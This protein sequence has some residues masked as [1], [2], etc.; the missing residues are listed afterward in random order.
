MVC[1]VGRY[2]CCCRKVCH[3][4]AVG[5]AGKRISFKVHAHVNTVGRGEAVSHHMA[6]DRVAHQQECCIDIEEK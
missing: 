6:A 1:Y 3:D 4:G 5:A 2:P